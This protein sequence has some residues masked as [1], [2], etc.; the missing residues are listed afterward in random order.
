MV[1]VSEVDTPPVI[2]SSLSVVENSVEK[3]RV[4]FNL[5]HLN[6]LLS[7]ESLKMKVHG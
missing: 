6:K 1:V 5:G 3:K 2:L 4:V 7:S